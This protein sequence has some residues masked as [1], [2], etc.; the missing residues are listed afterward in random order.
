M[1]PDRSTPGSLHIT[2]RECSSGLISTMLAM[3]LTVVCGPCPGYGNMGPNDCWW[4]WLVMTVQTIV[5]LLMDAVMIGVM[6]ARISHPKYRGRT[7]AISDSAVVSRRDGVLKFMF[8]IA[9]FRRTQVGGCCRCCSLHAGSGP[10]AC[11]CST[12]RKRPSIEVHV[13]DTIAAGLPLGRWSSQ[14]WRRTCTHGER[15]QP[16]VPTGDRQRKGCISGRLR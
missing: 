13:C 12:H 7:I 14:K 10:P 9:D 8:R 1:P 15:A 5:G 16:L 4:A 3:R 2:E 6:F 11:L